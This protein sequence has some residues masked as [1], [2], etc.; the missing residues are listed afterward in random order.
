MRD[1]RIK[2]IPAAS[3]AASAVPSAPSA[4]SVPGAATVSAA[5]DSAGSVALKVAASG[6]PVTRCFRLPTPRCDLHYGSI[7]R[8]K[9][10]A[11]MWRGCLLPAKQ[12]D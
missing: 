1:S 8:S 9:K 6:A 3:A 12:F 11:L 4:T 2:V 7:R 10:L 5:T